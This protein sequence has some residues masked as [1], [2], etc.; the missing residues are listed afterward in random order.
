MP[1][2]SDTVNPVN[3][4]R[5]RLR[6]V[7]RERRGAAGAAATAG[8]E[9]KLLHERKHS[10]AKQSVS[11]LR[12]PTHQRTNAC[13][14]RESVRAALWQTL[15]QPS[16]TIFTTASTGTQGGCRRRSN[17]KL[18]TKQMSY[19][20]PAFG[21]FGLVLCPPSWWWEWSGECLTGPGTVSREAV[22]QRV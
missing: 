13:G 7:R 17:N 3:V 12:S 10:S 4:V 14:E 15:A 8:R 19:F 9:R 11:A 6:L 16:R 20:G 5:L 2:D 18:T 1:H 21:L 22:K